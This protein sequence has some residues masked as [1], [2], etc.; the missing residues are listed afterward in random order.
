MSLKSARR[1]LLGLGVAFLAIQ[2]GIERIPALFEGIPHEYFIV[3]GVPAP[4]ALGAAF[5]LLA[6]TSW[7][8][9]KFKEAWDERAK[10]QSAKRS[11]PSQRTFP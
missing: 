5:I 10:Q 1:L 8:N 9:W 4:G 6:T 2:Y 3:S 11:E 7:L